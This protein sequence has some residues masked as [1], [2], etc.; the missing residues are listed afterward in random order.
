M[1]AT[2]QDLFARLESLGIATRTVAHE[3]VFTVAES[4]ELERDIPGGHSKS[5]FL[6]DTQ[7]AIFLVVAE[8]R[9][10]VDLKALAAKLGARRLSFG[11][12]DL[13]LKVL[14]VTPG[15]VTPFALINDGQRGLAAVVVDAGLE[16]HA[17]VNCH[18]LENTATTNIA[19][20]DLLRFIRACGYEPRIALL[21]NA[22]S[23]P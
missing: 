22:L 5:L 23:G 14:G 12:P 3:P 11:S 7:G 15:S 13:L 20:D 10:R 19:W 6:Q 9:T 17:T 18:P 16:R 2:R 8:S 4:A 1:P 21:G